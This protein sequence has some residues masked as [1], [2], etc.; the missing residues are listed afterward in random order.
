[1]HE[2]RCTKC[3][4]V[5]EHSGPT[6]D[7]TPETMVQKHSCPACGFH[8]RGCYLKLHPEDRGL[9]LAEWAYF[10]DPTANELPGGLAGLM[11]ETMDLIRLIRAALGRLLP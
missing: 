7:D 6:A 8:G 1:M 11:S 5:W 10:A 4:H 3:G 9:S 2:H